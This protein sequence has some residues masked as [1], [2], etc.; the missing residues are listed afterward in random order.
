MPTITINNGAPFRM[1]RR[2]ITNG[3]VD[4]LDAGVRG[5]LDELNQLLGK[6]VFSRDEGLGLMA[7]LRPRR[8][9]GARGRRGQ[10]NR[11]AGE[12]SGRLGLPLAPKHVPGDTWAD[13]SLLDWITQAAEADDKM[14]LADCIDV[15][16]ELSVLKAEFQAWFA[17]H[18]LGIDANLRGVLDEHPAIQ[19]FLVAMGYHVMKVKEVNGLANFIFRNRLGAQRVVNYAVVSATR[20]L[21]DQEQLNVRKYDDDKGDFVTTL[22]ASGVGLAE[23]E[24]KDEVH[25]VIRKFMFDSDEVELIEQADI[26]EIP[27]AIIPQLVKLIQ[28]SPIPI[29]KKNID[30]FLPLF[31]T[32]VQGLHP[33]AEE[34]GEVDLAISDQDFAVDFLEDDKALIKIS[35][36][37]V[38][39]AAQLYYSMVVGDELD[40]FGTMDYFTRRYMVRGDVKIEDRRLRE[41][42][43]MYVFSNRFTDPRRGTVLDRTRAGERQIFY[44]QVFDYGTAQVT[45]DL[46]P[47]REFKRLWKVLLLETDRYMSRAQ[48]SPNPES[49]VSKQNIQQAVEDLQ[50]NLSSHCTGMAN[51]ITPLIHAEVNFIARRVYQHR[52]ILRQVVP[53]GGTWWRVV[54]TL[55]SAMK[56]VRPRATVLYNKAYYGQL[57][58]DAIADY[59]AATFEDNKVFSPFVSNVASFITTESILREELVDDLK[60]RDRDEEELP[61]TNGRPSDDTEFEDAPAAAA[62]AAGGEWDF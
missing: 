8:P 26:G 61:A 55:Y 44:R 52:E 49:Y 22:A 46:I 51:V 53:A 4:D 62:P 24:F 42:L 9:G 29:D 59:D 25:R 10:R 27:K 19:D 45:E 30:H 2:A 12:L 50:Y 15:T 7:N 56:N 60:D 16:P 41:D 32:Q 14:T 34:P 28:A 11:A 6:R 40:V 38:K 43:Q 18:R 35:R 23:N 17:A 33:V 57:I 1:R 37:A 5:I 48:I 31:I 58:I 36:S 54:E 47:N 3:D 39:C 21:I 20:T 13:G